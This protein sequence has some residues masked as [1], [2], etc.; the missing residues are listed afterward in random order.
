MWQALGSYALTAVAHLNC[1]FSTGLD[2]AD[3]DPAFFFEMSDCISKQVQKYGTH[4]CG[5]HFSRG[6][7][8]RF[9]VT[10]AL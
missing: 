3:T 7:G 8:L 9:N 2:A 6:S 5:L 10:S 1:D 4:C